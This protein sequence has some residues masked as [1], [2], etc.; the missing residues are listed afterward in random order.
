[1]SQHHARIKNDP[2][3][4][5][6]RKACLDRDDQAC[7]E[8]GDEDGPLQVDHIYDLALILADH[9]PGRLPDDSLAFDL[10]N[11]RTLCVPCHQAK[12]TT[13]LVRQPWCHPDYP[14]LADL[15]GGAPVF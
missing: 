6:A 15:I 12:A 10:D 7:T 5:A 14:E 4:K 3:W 1:V 9:G 11:L 8:C 2:R 13:T